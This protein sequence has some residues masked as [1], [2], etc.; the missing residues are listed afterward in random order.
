MNATTRMPPPLPIAP[1]PSGKS[2]DWVE[3]F[4]EA[5]QIIAGMIEGDVALRETITRHEDKDPAGVSALLWIRDEID[6]LV[7]DLTGRDARL[8]NLKGK[9]Q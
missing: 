9:I 2:R 3:G 4:V 1:D 6:T 5:A 8:E 7:L